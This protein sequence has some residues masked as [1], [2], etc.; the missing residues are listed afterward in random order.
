MNHMNIA[1]NRSDTPIADEVTD[2]TE[3]R[4]LAFLEGKLH[5]LLYELP[6]AGLNRDLHLQTLRAKIN[7][8]KTEL[9]GSIS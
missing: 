8:I 1:R 3:T 5:A 9:N 4:R 2:L 7:K 6:N